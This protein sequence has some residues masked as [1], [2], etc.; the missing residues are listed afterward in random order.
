MLGM[1]TIAVEAEDENN[2]ASHSIPPRRGCSCPL[3][4]GRQGRGSQQRKT[5]DNPLIIKFFQTKADRPLL[6][7]ASAP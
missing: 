2:F 7:L 4:L 1:V 3:K 6:L 5:L